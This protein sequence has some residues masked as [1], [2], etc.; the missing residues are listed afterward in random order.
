MSKR[1]LIRLDTEQIQVIN[2]ATELLSRILIGQPEELAG[3]FISSPKVDQE[4]L[5]E[6]LDTLKTIA[7]PRLTRTQHY[8]IMS[9]EVPEKA[10]IAFDIYQVTRSHLTW[11]DHFQGEP[12]ATGLDQPFRTAVDHT[13][14]RMIG[15]GE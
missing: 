13:L 4:K 12:S 14:P 8:G 15:V 10:R 6:V 3:L 9:G 5:R 2:E 7:F 1:Y 11:D